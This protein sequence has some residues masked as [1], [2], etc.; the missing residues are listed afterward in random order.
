MCLTKPLAAYLHNIMQ[1]AD[2]RSQKCINRTPCV[3][4]C[5]TLGPGFES[6]RLPPVS[7][8]HCVKLSMHSLCARRQPRNRA[9]ARWPHLHCLQHPLPPVTEPRFFKFDTSAV[10]ASV[11]GSDNSLYSAAV[12]PGIATVVSV[13][14]SL[15]SLHAQRVESRSLIMCA[16]P[17][18]Q[19][20]GKTQFGTRR[21]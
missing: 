2:I 9:P 8:S 1:V 19:L 11:N 7:G 20:E 5:N 12:V 15:E 17:T 3:S 13:H 6:Q 21:V 18:D 16:C 10:P 4:M 14:K